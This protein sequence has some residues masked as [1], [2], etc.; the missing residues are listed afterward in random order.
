MHMQGE[1]VDSFGLAWLGVLIPWQKRRVS[2][3]AVAVSHGSRSVREP[4]PLG[5]RVGGR[6]ILTDV[7]W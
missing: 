3:R 7:R 5:G 4:C 1:T 2:L 6:L